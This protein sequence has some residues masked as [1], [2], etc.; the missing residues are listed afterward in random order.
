MNE[1][2]SIKNNLIIDTLKLKEK[3]SQ[4][5][6][7]KYLTEGLNIVKESLDH[8]IVEVIFCTKKHI[9]NFKNF[10][11]LYL[12]SENVAQ[13]LSDVKTN[14]EVFAICRFEN[15][16]LFEQNNLLVL[17]N[18][19]DPGNLG[20]LIRSAKAFGFK[21]ILC[22]QD[23]VSLYNP[24]VLR[25]VQAN[26]LGMHIEYG[27]IK[28]MLNNLK[29]KFKIIT[30]KLG[31]KNDLDIIYQQKEHQYALV[32]GNEGNGVSEE[33][34]QL[35]DYNCILNLDAQV[36]SLNVAIAGSILMYN[37]AN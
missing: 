18:I 22:S 14:Q 19:Q 32:L 37:L 26:H 28:T 9:D 11:N 35:S 8:N 17:D 13:K 10:E 33:I 6:E 24:K 30:T 27:D 29:S 25:A 3:K 4:F 16:S 1:I 23:T 21:N 12:I 5:S 34:Y 7:Q 2:T 36:E 31:Q 15:T 20:T